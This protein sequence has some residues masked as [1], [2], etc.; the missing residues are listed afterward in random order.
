MAKFMSNG[1]SDIACEINGR[2]FARCLPTISATAQEIPNGTREHVAVKFVVL[3]LEIL[4]RH[5]KIG[6]ISNGRVVTYV[7][8]IAV[9]RIGV[10]AGLKPSFS[11]ARIEFLSNFGCKEDSKVQLRIIRVRR[12]NLPYL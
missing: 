1:V 8:D 2:K 4:M 10:L 5:P 7:D 12:E 3:S 9:V 6:K 11:R